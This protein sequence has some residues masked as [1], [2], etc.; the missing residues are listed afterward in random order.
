M[1]PI[2]ALQAAFV[3]SS[4]LCVVGQHGA[5]KALLPGL[6][7]EQ[8]LGIVTIRAVAADLGQLGGSPSNP[9]ECG[10]Q[11]QDRQD[12]SKVLRRSEKRLTRDRVLSR[13]NRNHTNIRRTCPL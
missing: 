10:S 4:D 8:M 2:G 13:Q 3:V 9:E 6:T 12:V 11:S 5:Y 7:C 1:T